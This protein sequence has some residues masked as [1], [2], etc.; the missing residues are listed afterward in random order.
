MIYICQLQSSTM[1]P[2]TILTNPHDAFLKGNNRLKFWNRILVEMTLKALMKL[3]MVFL[4][5]HQL[6]LQ[7]ATNRLRFWIWIQVGRIQTVFMILEWGLAW[8]FPKMLQVVGL[9]LLVVVSAQFLLVFI[10]LPTNLLDR[11]PPCNRLE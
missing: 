8:K 9:H 10:L 1:V 2:L 6:V 7:R 3:G 11:E 5:N 4:C